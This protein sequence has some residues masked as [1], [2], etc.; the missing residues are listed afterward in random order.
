ME[1]Y[2]MYFPC[3]TIGHGVYE[4]V[5]KVCC[6]YGT[7]AVIIGG[8]KA[9]AAAQDKLLQACREGGITVTGILWYGGECAYENVDRLAAEKPWHWIITF[10]PKLNDPKLISDYEQLAQRHQNVIF[11]RVNKG[12]ETF[13]QSDVMLC[14]SSS[15][16]LEY[17]MLGKPV[18]TFCN[19]HPGPHLID[20]RDEQLVGPAIERALTR[21]AE[22]MHAISDYT[23]HHEAHRDG[24]N[25]A[26]VLDAVDD[27]IENYQGRMRRKPLNLFRKLKLRWKLK[28]WAPI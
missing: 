25:A 19:T 4:K 10:H 5:G 18:V 12:L 21:P 23:A 14:D 6:D 7:S 13:R 3:Y 1:G 28:Y 22:L 9:L 20:V 27:F 16:T 15:I 24:H 11:S 2:S 17:M 8:H 26:R